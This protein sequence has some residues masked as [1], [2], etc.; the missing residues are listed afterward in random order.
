[1][2]IYKHELR[3]NS[4]AW[5]GWTLAMILVVLFYSAFY[6]MIHSQ[7]DVFKN[8]LGN[9]PQGVEQGFGFNADT[10]SNI[11]SFFVFVFGFASLLGAIQAMNLG[12][13]I[14][15]KEERERTAD[16]L[17]TKPVSRTRIFVEK[18]LAALTIFVV[19]DI[20]FAG[21]TGPALT[22]IGGGHLNKKAFVLICVS[23]LMMQG[24]FF[25]IG[26]IISVALK[27]IHAVL[28]I[29]LGVV[30]AFYLISAF[31]VQGSTGGLRLI[32]PFQ[33]FPGSYILQNLAKNKQHLFS[34]H[35]GP[36]TF[37]GYDPLYLIVGAAL[38]AIC[39]VVSYILYKKRNIHAV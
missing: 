7:A 3:A 22:A 5:F 15:S 36:G 38:V 18:L 11:T 19:T 14:L 10:F 20:I 6:P 26:L 39:F 30:F 28:P 23:L 29:S 32:T 1:M 8:Y 17:M 25:A 12:I 9:M 21:I 31:A 16:F 27:K 24:M 34:Y 4:K 2:N 33:Y 13:G 37:F 35:G